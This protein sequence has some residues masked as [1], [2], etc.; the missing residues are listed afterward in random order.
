M[1]LSHPALGT[2][3]D[4]KILQPLVLGPA[5][6]QTLRKPVLIV[7]ISDGTPAGEAPDHVFKVIA[8]ASA[9][10][11]RTSYGKDALSIMFSRTSLSTCSLVAGADNVVS[12]PCAEL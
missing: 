2:A 4:Q 7:A 9:E 11:S 12:S 6:S 8:N 10:L 3:L 5:R 1:S